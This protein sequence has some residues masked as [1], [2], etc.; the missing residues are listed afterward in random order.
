MQI[1]QSPSG[2]KIFQIVMV[3]AIAVIVIVIVSSLLVRLVFFQNW[4]DQQF[5]S[6]YFFYYLIDYYFILSLLYCIFMKFIRERH[7]QLFAFY[8]YGF[9]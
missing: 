1:V 3:I 4:L 9:G 8:A 5:Q 2:A 6:G 7:D